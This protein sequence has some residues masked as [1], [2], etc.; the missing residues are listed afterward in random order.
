MKA[1]SGLRKFNYILIKSI[2]F[3]EIHYLGWLSSL[4]NP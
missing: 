1:H 4:A 2:R 3:V